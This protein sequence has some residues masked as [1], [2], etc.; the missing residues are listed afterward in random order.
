[1][2]WGIPEFR[3]IH[4]LQLAALTGRLQLQHVFDYLRGAVA[5]TCSAPGAYSDIALGG[6]H[7]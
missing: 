7:A 6:M 2:K 4:R 3:I 1:M 5:C